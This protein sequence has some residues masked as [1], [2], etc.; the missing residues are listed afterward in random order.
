MI[1]EPKKVIALGIGAILCAAAACFMALTGSVPG[2]LTGIASA[3]STILGAFG[4]KYVIPSL[5]VK[6]KDK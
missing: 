6:E 3:L 4:I 2:W 5:D 1:K